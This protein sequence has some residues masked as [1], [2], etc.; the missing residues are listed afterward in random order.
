MKGSSK[1]HTISFSRLL[2]GSQTNLIGEGGHSFVY[3]G[4]LEPNDEKFVVV[5]IITSC[6]S[7]NLHGNDFKGLVYEFMS[8]GSVH[9][10]LYSSASSSK[11]N[12]LQRINI[13]RDVATALDYL[14]NHCQTTIV[15]GDLKP[16]NV[17]LDY[18]MVAHVGDFGLARLLG[19]NLNQNSSSGVKGT[20]GCAPLEYGIGSEMT[21]SGDIYS[22]G[23]LLLELITGKRLTDDMFNNGLNLH[24]FAYMA[25]LDHVVDVIDGDAKIMLQSTKTNVKKV[26]ECLAAII[27]IGVSCYVDSPTHRRKIEIVVIELQC[28]SSSFYGAV[29]SNFNKDSACVTE[30]AGYQQIRI[31]GSSIVQVMGEEDEHSSL[32]QGLANQQRDKRMTAAKFEVEKFD[33]TRDFGLW[34]IKMRA[35]LIQ[36]GNNFLREVTGETTA[37]GN[38]MTTC[39]YLSLWTGSFDFGGRDSHTKFK[40]IKERSKAK[41]DDGEGLYVRGRIDRRDSRQSRGKS[42]SKSQGAVYSWVTTGS[43]RS[44]VLARVVLSGIR[45]HNYVYSLDG[46]AMVG[47]LNASVEEK[48]SFAQLVENQTG[49]TVKKLRTDNGLEFCNREFEQLCI[50]SRITRHL[51]VVGTPQKNGL[52]ERMNRTL[53]DKRLRKDTYGDVAGTSKYPE[54]VKGYRLYR[55]DDESPKIV[56]SRNVV[57]NESAMY[58]DTLKDS[59]AGADKSVVELQSNM[60]AY[61]FVA[62]EEEDTL[63]PLTYH[64]AVAYEDSSNWKT[65]MKEEMYSLRKNK[66]WELVDHPARQKLVCCKWL[67]KIKEGIKGVQ[68]SR[69]KARLAARGFMHLEQFDVKTEFLHGNLEELPRQWYM[70]FD[71]YMLSNRFK[72]SSYDNSVYYMSYVQGDYIYLLLYVD[73]MLIACKS[74]AKIRS[75]KSLL[76]K[77]F[78]IKELGEAKKIL[79][80]EIARD[81]NRK[82]LRVSQSGYVSKILNNF[83][84]NNGKS[85]KM[86]L[87]GHFKLPL[88]DCSVEDYDV[89][90]MST[91][92]YANAVR[93]LMYLMV[94][95]RPDIAYAVNL[96]Y[97]IDRGNHVDVTGFVDSDYAKDPEKERELTLVKTLGKEVDEYVTKVIAKYGTVT[98]FEGRFPHFI[99]EEEEKKPK[100]YNLYGFVNLMKNEQVYAKNGLAPHRIPQPEGNHNGWLSEEEEADS[101]S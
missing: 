99:E 19:R 11:L 85:V 61:V 69:Y 30:A 47:D 4:I 53:M 44:K 36:H 59:G 40:D 25:L 35:L 80:I 58:K 33:G 41:G 28:L 90:R 94:C 71:E 97:G 96:V 13:L 100:P 8:N 3:K 88:K 76:K 75:T 39:G 60:D 101:D 32:S 22:F 92:P 38:H 64:E 55:L 98:R 18:D 68:K 20:I 65:S 78:D 46:H 10:W 54:G 26:E 72:R 23:I 67:F 91:V 14:H 52:A 57:F 77:E 9:N 87:G 34:R 5:K 48:D 37:T 45:R 31:L 7:V 63:E 49:R 81:R 21:S 73:D 2:M 12:L 43:V 17:L 79:G 62:A 15:H 16:S 93:S 29:G 70:R 56:A 89:E 95:T 74:K 27:K 24:K 86:S 51:I 83:R 66:T 1:F 84:I 50:E 42:R 82:I 6:S